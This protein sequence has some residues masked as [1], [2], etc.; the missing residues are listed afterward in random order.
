MLVSPTECLADCEDLNFNCRFKRINDLLLTSNPRL[1]RSCSTAQ[2][3][4]MSR[5]LMFIDP[6]LMEVGVLGGG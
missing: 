6:N 4:S 2:A 5:P 3:A 1:D